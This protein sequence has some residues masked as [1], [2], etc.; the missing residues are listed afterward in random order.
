MLEVHIDD[1]KI[2]DDSILSTFNINERIQP[3]Q[4]DYV[5][6]ETRDEWKNE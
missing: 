2:K 3:K 6:Q 4:R 1:D 5:S